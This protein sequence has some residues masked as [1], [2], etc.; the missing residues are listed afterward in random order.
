MKQTEIQK[1]IICGQGVMHC[2]L[3]LFYKVKIQR[4][5]IDIKAVTR[6]HGLEQFMGNAMLANIMGPDEDIANP[7]D[8]E[9]EAFVCE[10]C[11][12]GKQQCIAVIAQNIYELQEQKEVDDEKENTNNRCRG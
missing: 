12:T 4:F 10:E 3:P 11:S 7:I 1:C 6:Q 2:G 8:D 9:L 5:G